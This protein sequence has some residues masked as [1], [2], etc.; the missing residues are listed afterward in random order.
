LIDSGRVVGYLDV[1]VEKSLREDVVGGVHT[2]FVS[3]RHGEV[4]QEEPAPYVPEPIPVP[5]AAPSP[6]KAAGL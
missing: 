4:E 3:L 6:A 1:E 2:P 5:V